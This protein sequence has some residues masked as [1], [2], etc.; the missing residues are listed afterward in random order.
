MALL[1]ASVGAAAIVPK[2]AQDTNSG[3]YQV[4]MFHCYSIDNSHSDC[5]YFH[6]RMASVPGVF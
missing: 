4:L 2:E 6:L 3:Q 1:A 5:A